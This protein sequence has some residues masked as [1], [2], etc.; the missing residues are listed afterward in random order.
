MA[1]RNVK[2]YFKNEKALMKELGLNSVP[3][4]GNGIIKEDGQNEYIIAQL[5]STDAASI[6]IKQTDVNV[7]FYNAIITHKIP[8][9]INQF[10]DGQTLISMRLEDIPDVANYII[11]G[12]A[13]CREECIVVEDKPKRITSVITSTKRK[14]VK[15]KLQKEREET[16]KKR[17]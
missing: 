11:C 17:K 5:K 12:K 8:I 1:K 3:G 9:F 4:S 2:F 14:Q 6:S 7:L 15:N 10:L 13:E 16:Y